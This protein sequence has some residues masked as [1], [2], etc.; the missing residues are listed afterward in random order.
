MRILVT[1]ADGFVGRALCPHLVALGHEVVP[2]VHK[3]SLHDNKYWD[4]A[5]K[6]C[7]SVIHLAA[8]S[9][10]VKYQDNRALQWY[11]E[12]NV[13]FTIELANK[14]LEAGVRRFVFMSSIKV[15]G[16]YTDPKSCFKS[17]DPVSPQDSYAIS[18]WEAEKKLNEFA[19][20]TGLE[21]VI[22]RPPLVY[23]PGVKG[24]FA[25]LIRWVKKG[26]PLP[27]GAVNNRRSMIALDNLID[28]TA[29]CADYQ[30]SPSAT[31]EVFLVSDDEDVSTV[32]LLQ[33]I[34]K[35][36]GCHIHLLPA[37]LAL[38]RLVARCAGKLPYAHRLIN[39]LVIDNSKPREM[40]GW[41]PPVSMGEQLQKMVMYDSR[42]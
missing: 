41:S 14:A 38:I 3:S 35:A 20:N 28:F 15:N 21:L 34:A 5:F 10:M 16:E 23:G 29:L 26:I 42:L 19:R 17:D 40:L 8:R 2:G 33:N 36:Y 22:I 7:N 30:A 24:N 1:G 25:S 37:P 11:L 12:N 9:H 13:D 18:K 27:L 6:G 31:G 39:S 4:T 32:E